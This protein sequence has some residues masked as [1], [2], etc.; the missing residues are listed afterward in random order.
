MGDISVKTKVKIVAMTL[1]TATET[2]ILATRLTPTIAIIDII[3]IKV[4]GSLLTQLTKVS[5]VV[6]V[7]TRRNKEET[8]NTQGPMIDTSIAVALIVKTISRELAA[9]PTMETIYTI[10]PIK[11]VKI[12]GPNIIT[13]TH[14]IRSQTTLYFSSL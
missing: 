4:F 9:I 3:A 1:T 2:T 14:K 7:I 10:G 13:I 8:G 5:Q 11:T 12:G 6:P